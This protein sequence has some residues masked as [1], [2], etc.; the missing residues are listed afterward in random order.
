V[1]FFNTGNKHFQVN[2]YYKAKG[3]DHTYRI[4]SPGI[5]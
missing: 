4:D 1:K 3:E 2:I 5:H